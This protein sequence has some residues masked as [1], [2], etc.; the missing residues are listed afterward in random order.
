MGNI[1]KKDGF[2]YWVEGH[3]GFETYYNMG[4]D[5]D[6]E[7]WNEEL[8]VIEIEEKDD[9]MLEIVPKKTNKKTKKED[10]E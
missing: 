5:Q 8:E 2:V 3:K 9:G 7:R 1:V 6:D 10:T 4:K